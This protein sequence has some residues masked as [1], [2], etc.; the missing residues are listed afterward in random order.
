ME[1]YGFTLLSEEEVVSTGLP[2]ST[3]MFEEL[4]NAMEIEINMNKK[5]SSNFK[6][7]TT[8]TSNEKFVSFLNR[9]FIFR[10]RRNVDAEKI[11]KKVLSKDMETI[12]EEEK[13]SEDED[14]PKKNKQTVRIKK[15]KEDDGAVKKTKIVIKKKK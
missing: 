11:M 3:G 5:L 1:N 15:R 4:F 9:Y 2:N 13:E 7:A 12:E 8:M 10:K 6:N 14:E